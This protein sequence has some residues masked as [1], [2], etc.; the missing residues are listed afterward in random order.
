MSQFALG[1]GIATGV[2]QLGTSI[3]GANDRNRAIRKRMKAN[4]ANA[5]VELEQQR[6]IFAVQSTRSRQN[7]A[8]TM[9]LIGVTAAERGVGS[10]GSVAALERNVAA[11][12][13]LNDY[14]LDIERFGVE[15]RTLSQLNLA[16][17]GL[18]EQTQPL[19]L[20]AFGGA[21][22]GISTGLSIGRGLGELL[23]PP[24][25]TVD[26]LNKIGVGW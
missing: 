3:F 9:G 2:L 6:R 13:E 19:A 11:D 4:N 10:G 16:Q 17:M 23:G 21:A 8:S 20:A 1:A 18:E 14:A 15:R 25:M 22:Q 24:K 26:D 5:A 12:Q 7:A